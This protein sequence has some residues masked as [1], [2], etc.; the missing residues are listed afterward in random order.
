MQAK[1]VP[2][3]PS[4]VVAGFLWPRAVG[5]S[6]FVIWN[7]RH[8]LDIVRSKDKYFLLKYNGN[9]CYEAELSEGSSNFTVSCLHV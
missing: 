8:K 3:G 4:L 6:L 9:E 2:T 5:P 7:C 1:L